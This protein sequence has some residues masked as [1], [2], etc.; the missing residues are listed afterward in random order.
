MPGMEPATPLRYVHVE[1]VMGTMVSLDL[2]DRG[3]VSAAVDRVVSWLHVV[4]RM[5]SPYRETSAISQINRGTLRQ[6]DADPLVTEVLWRCD[7]LRDRTDGFFDARASG[8]LDPSALVKGWA[9]Q[10]AADRLQA[11]GFRNFCLSAGGDVVTRGLPEPDQVWRIG[12][13]HPR[14]PSSIAAVL[15]AGELAVATSGTYERGEHITDPHTGE[16]PHGLLSVTV[17]GPDLGTADAL[18]TAVFAMGRAGADWTGSADWSESLKD[19]QAMIIV[20]ED[21]VLS[22]PGFPYAVDQGTVT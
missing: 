12:V 11:E 22:T 15:E 21:L 2:R 14:E 6:A 20:D 7:Q 8:R 3:P 4:D 18:S 13:Q 19:Y 10:V 16:P 17:C 9:I 1:A 5:F